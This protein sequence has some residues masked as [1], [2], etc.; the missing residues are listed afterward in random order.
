VLEEEH[1]TVHGGEKVHPVHLFAERLMQQSV[2]EVK[3]LSDEAHELG[4]LRR[5]V[6][7]HHT[8]RK[9]NQM[10][11]LLFLFGVSF[12]VSF[13]VPFGVRVSSYSCFWHTHTHVTRPRLR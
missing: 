1:F 12:G 2:G 3:L 9:Q 5:L 4:Q 11:P 7:V 13:G 8:R 10:S 6:K